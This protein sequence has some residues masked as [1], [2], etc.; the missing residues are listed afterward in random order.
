MLRDWP[1]WLRAF[2]VSLRGELL[3][4]PRLIP[5]IATRPVMNLGSLRSVEKVVAALCK[6]ELNPLRAFH[7]INTVTTFV[8]GHTLAEAGSTPG[9]EDFAEELGNRLDHNEFPCISEAIRRGLGSSEDHQARFE[10]GLDA[11]FAGFVKTACKYPNI[12]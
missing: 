2:A 4:H 7:I 11:L 12:V 1:I 3:R 6:A 10:F 5:L 9:H 8:T